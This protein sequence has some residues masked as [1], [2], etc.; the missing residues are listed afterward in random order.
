MKDVRILENIEKEGMRWN[1]MENSNKLREENW[2][3]K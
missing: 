1:E 3:I 2:N